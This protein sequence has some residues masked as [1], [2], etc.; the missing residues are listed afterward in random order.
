MTSLL[1]QRGFTPYL[2]ALFLNAFVDLGHKII[3]QNTIFK[4]YDG[5]TQIM[6]TALVNALILMPYIALFLPAGRASDR[7]AKARV[8]QFGA[9]AAVLL[10]LGIT[11]CYYQGWFWPAFG[12][13]L[14]LAVQ[15]AFYSPAKYGYIRELLGSERLANGNGAVQA[16]TII[17]IL[18]GTLAFSILFEWLY[19]GAG[20][21]SQI[22]LGVAPLGWALVG[23]SVLAF[24]FCLVL[25]LKPPV[26]ALVSPVPAVPI[27]ARRDLRRPI[28]GLT[29]FWTVSQVL[30]AA[31]PAHAKDVLQETNVVVVQGM[32]AA[33]GVGILAGSL[34]AGR[35][36][37]GYINAAL[38]LPG[39]VGIVAGLVLLPLL[40]SVWQAML[41]FLALGVAG[42]LFI[43][44]LNALLQFHARQREL[45]HVLALNNVVQNIA[46]LAGLAVTAFAAWRGSSAFGILWSLVGLGLLGG[47]YVLRGYADW[48]W[49]WQWRRREGHWPRL[50]VEGLDN[51]PDDAALRIELDDPRGLAPLILPMACPHQLYRVNGRWQ[52]GEAE[53]HHPVRVQLRDGGNGHI[54]VR[55]EAGGV[56]SP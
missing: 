23:L 9:L 7:F 46:M 35:W 14:L 37:R 8:L 51:L 29:L 32:M 17:A 47:A 28:L 19:Q 38:L 6:L 56:R 27:L 36:S 20:T 53:R 10:T 2:I 15:S 5:S 33:S 50:S 22:L 45:G 16:V 30:L 44:P 26:P 52:S 12:M 41:T 4:V 49:R 48:R 1:R 42:G 25:P 40:P 39:V 31:F 3:I 43:V 18:G 24:L 34:L 55:F 21:E 54:R 11:A 13:T